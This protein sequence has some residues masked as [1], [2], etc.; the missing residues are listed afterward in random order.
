MYFCAGAPG[1]AVALANASVINFNSLTDCRCVY[2]AVVADITRPCPH[3]A[4]SPE[5]PPA[6]GG[7]RA[8]LGEGLATAALA[9]WPLC[10]GGLAGT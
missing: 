2:G 1:I 3:P 8:H 5:S 10:A 7:S 4:P 9:R 6:P